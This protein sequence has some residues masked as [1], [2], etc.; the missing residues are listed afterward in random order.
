MRLL[1]KTPGKKFH[2]VTAS[3]IRGAATPADQFELSPTWWSQRIYDFN[4]ILLDRLRGSILR[5]ADN[6]HFLYLATI[7]LTQWRSRDG[8]DY[9]VLSRRSA[10]CLYETVKLMRY[11]IRKVIQYGQKH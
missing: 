6:G 3:S 4:K 1:N 5:G 8:S 11:Y 7:T 10:L 2:Q 9:K